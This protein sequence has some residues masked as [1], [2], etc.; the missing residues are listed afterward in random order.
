[1]SHEHKAEPAPEPVEQTEEPRDEKQELI[2]HLQRLQAEFDNY[3][4]RVERDQTEHR[5]QASERLLKELLPIIDNFDLALKHA[6][7]EHGHV[8]GEDL[9]AG[10]VMIHDQLKALLEHQGITEMK[11]EGKFDPRQHEALMMVDHAGA[12]R[13]TILQVYQRGYLRGAKVFRPA[14]VSV[15]K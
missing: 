1:M 14:K 15:A 9:L 6:K 8:K 7:D 12:E 3:R 4:R 13:G 5:E 11:A 2:S 10:N